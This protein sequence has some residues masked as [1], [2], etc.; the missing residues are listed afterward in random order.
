MRLASQMLVAGALAMASTAYAAGYDLAQDWSPPANPDGTWSFLS[1]STALPYWNSVTPLNG[2]GGYAPSPNWGSFLPLFWQSNGAGSDIF[3]HSYDGANGGGASGEAVLA[4]TSPVTG[5]LDVT[6][7]IY[8]A[9]PTY[10]RSNDITLQL[11]GQTLVSAV[12]SYAQYADY[13]HRL[14]FSF[15]GLAVNAGEPLTLTMVRSVGQVYGTIN[16]VELQLVANPVP[17]PAA[18]AMLLAGL[19]VVG[20][21]R[22]GRTIRR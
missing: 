18:A 21:A 9:Q 5:T 10:D 3:I 12:V 15:T 1:G 16:G 11:G 22:R 8:Y 2:A 20:L 19:G 7:Y 14:S 13:D 6:G 17:E 4:W